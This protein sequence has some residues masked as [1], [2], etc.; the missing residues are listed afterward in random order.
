MQNL[1]FNEARWLY[2]PRL[3]ATHGPVVAQPVHLTGAQKY[4]ADIALEEL[5]LGPLANFA[6]YESMEAS[7]A[8]GNGLHKFQKKLNNDINNGL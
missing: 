8:V 1:S 6:G 7:R 5:H 3:L 2:R 4:P